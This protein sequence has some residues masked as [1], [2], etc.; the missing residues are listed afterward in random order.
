M[1]FQI[2]LAGETPIAKETGVDSY[3]REH[4]CHAVVVLALM[5]Q[6]GHRLEFSNYAT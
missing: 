4:N 3:N 5:I 2:D 6:S 1:V